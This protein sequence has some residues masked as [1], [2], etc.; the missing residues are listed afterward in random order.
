MIFGNWA[1]SAAIESSPPAPPGGCGLVEDGVPGLQHTVLLE[2]ATG[3]HDH[4]DVAGVTARDVR[5]GQQA[6]VIEVDHDQESRLNAARSAGGGRTA[7]PARTQG[8]SRAV[9]D[10]GP[11]GTAPA[12][13]CDEEED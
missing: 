4:V 6:G 8:P 13:R 12:C 11:V 3:H 2:D 5:G 10:R 9:S 1:H 7:E